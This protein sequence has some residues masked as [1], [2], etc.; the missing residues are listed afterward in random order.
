[1]SYVLSILAILAAVMWLCLALP[2]PDE[3]AIMW[4]HTGKT[5]GVNWR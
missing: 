3:R 2:T 5:T 4:D 1:V